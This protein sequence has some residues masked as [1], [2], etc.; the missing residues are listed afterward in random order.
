[1]PEEREACY[2]KV[3]STLVT[4]HVTEKRGGL[5]FGLTFISEEAPKMP[6]RRLMELRKEDS[7]NWRG[8]SHKGKNGVNTYWINGCLLRNFYFFHMFIETQGKILV[9]KQLRAQQN[10]EDA[11]IK[12]QIE[13]AHKEMARL[14]KYVN[15]KTD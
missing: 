5:A 9:R 4:D 14:E 7:Q 12:K 13:T 11:R 2:D 10:R 3:R 15:V 6:P 1:M 8:M